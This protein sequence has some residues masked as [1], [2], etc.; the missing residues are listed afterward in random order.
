MKTSNK[1]FGFYGVMNCFFD[2]ESTENI[3]ILMM[4]KLKDLYPYKTDDD[5]V[6]FLDSRPGR[7]LAHD[8]L[9]DSKEISLGTLMVKIALLNQTELSTSWLYYHM[10]NPIPA[11]V[12][13]KFVYKNAIEC[14][15]KKPDIKKLMFD[16]LEYQD[17]NTQQDLKAWLEA[18]S[19]TAQELEIMWGQIHEKLSKR[20][21]HGND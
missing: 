12:N 5:L 7:H 6:K 19:T 1:E 2:G 13:K 17:T 11:P 3:W 16:L 14:H 10:G 20:K 18:D 9:G 4:K 15:I 8:L 21:K